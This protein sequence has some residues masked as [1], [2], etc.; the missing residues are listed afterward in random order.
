MR[1]RQ[2]TTRNNSEKKA[3]VG[4]TFYD[5]IGRPAVQVLPVPDN[6]GLVNFRA[7]FNNKGVGTPYTAEYIDKNKTG[8][9]SGADA[10]ESISGIGAA[11]Y[12]SEKN[13][14]TDGVGDGKVLNRDFIPKAEGYPFTQTL[15]TPDNTGRVAAQS[16]VGEAYRL[17]DN[18][19]FTE[20]F[21]GS[22]MQEELDRLF[23][24]EA[25]N[26]LRYQ[27][28]IVKDPNGQY[29][30]S[31]LD[32][33]G[34][35]IAT[36]LVGLGLDNLEDLPVAAGADQKQIDSELLGLKGVTQSGNGLNATGD[37][38]KYSKNIVLAQNTTIDLSYTAGLPSYETKC[39]VVD[40]SIGAN[41]K[42][43]SSDPRVVNQKCYDCVLEYELSLRNSQCPSTELLA[44]A[45]NRIG[46]L[47]D[48][49]FECTKNMLLTPANA[50]S[51]SIGAG[52]YTLSKTLRVNEEKL[53]LHQADYLASLCVGTLEQFQS[54]ELAKADLTSC[55]AGTCDDC[56][57]KVGS[58]TNYDGMDNTTGDVSA[59]ELKLSQNQYEEILTVC[60][61]L[62]KDEFVCDALSL[63][64]ESDFT[65]GGQYG[66]VLKKTAASSTTSSFDPNTGQ[67]TVSTSGGFFAKTSADG[68]FPSA[69]E[70]TGEMNPA[71]HIL[72]IYNENNRLP[73]RQRNI[74]S[75]NGAAALLAMKPSWRNPLY[76]DADKNGYKRHFYENDGKTVVYLS[77][78]KLPKD[79]VEYYPALQSGY[80]PIEKNGEFFAEPQ[81]LADV[82]DFMRI[83]KRSWMKSLL[84]YH[85][86][87][88]YLQY[89]WTNDK[90]ETV[91]LNNKQDLISSNRFDQLW[92]ETETY[93]QA[94]DAGFIVDGQL[95][96]PITG[97]GMKLKDPFWSYAGNSFLKIYGKYLLNNKYKNA[98]DEDF[99]T[100]GSMD[101]WTMANQ[102]AN[103]PGKE[104][105]PCLNESC[106]QKM[107][108]NDAEWAAFRSLYYA[109]KKDIMRDDATR[110]SIN[111]YSFNGCIGAKS[112]DNSWVIDNNYFMH[113]EQ[114][115]EQFW[116]CQTSEYWKIGGVNG[117]MNNGFAIFPETAL[118]HNPG[119]TQITIPESCTSTN[120]HFWGLKPQRCISYNC[121]LAS[122]PLSKYSIM[123]NSQ[124]CTYNSHSLYRDKKK[125]SVYNTT[126]TSVAGL[127]S[128]DKNC[129]EPVLG[130]DG[131]TAY[132]PSTCPEDVKELYDEMSAQATQS[133]Y[134]ECGQCPIARSLQNFISSLTQTNKFIS[135]VSNKVQ[136][137]CGAGSSKDVNFSPDLKAIVDDNSN[138][139]EDIF[140]YASPESVLTS[141]GFKSISTYITRAGV[142]R[143]RL[144]FKMK[145]NS[146][147]PQTLSFN[148]LVEVCCLVTEDQPKWI[149]GQSG[150]YYF[151][152]KGTYFVD[153]PD[154]Y[155]KDRKEVD[156]E[157]WT[158]CFDLK[159]C[160]PIPPK[161][162]TSKEIGKLTD[163]L[164]A[165]TTRIPN[166]PQNVYASYTNNPSDYAKVPLLISGDAA[167]LPLDLYGDNENKVTYFSVVSNLF[168]SDTDPTALEPDP[169]T[170]GN[171]V[172]AVKWKGQES[173]ITG[174]ESFKSKF[175]G[176]IT[177]DASPGINSTSTTPVQKTVDVF[178][179]SK[180]S[181]F[182]FENIMSFTR[183]KT[184]KEIGATDCT[185]NCSNYTFE[186]D[187]I[188]PNPVVGEPTKKVRLYGTTN[189]KTGICKPVI[190]F[191]KI[192]LGNN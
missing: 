88:G 95:P 60:D 101:I 100:R 80:T 103:C 19:H 6:S 78:I 40:Y 27:K 15:Y 75:D 71:E 145:V 76:F 150:G 127:G 144:E 37:E 169:T 26:S 134:A 42:V 125:V 119:A 74:I 188:V 90:N 102:I 171:L 91:V 114:S 21:Y 36:S 20:Y 130:A 108:R 56:R 161:C 64:M 177:V 156:I 59:T 49:T 16:G 34:K 10:F 128:M 122:I 28:N 84:P 83:R 157:V 160:L 163:L 110:Y 180:E 121:G 51:V 173:S 98:I 120:W 11:S 50:M 25:G 175:E 61:A 182:K 30:V 167:S 82:R 70:S 152:V 159:K 155:K 168:N 135:L 68:I 166:D 189:L 140:W 186:V 138:P 179:Y 14:F 132:V 92:T 124:S 129:W 77:V 5:Y 58:Y 87:Y 33:V 72:S 136:L 1:T 99:K 4:E 190:A 45:T 7:N 32:P 35:V 94:I 54:E 93:Q 48:Q 55:D 187:V 191:E 23:G 176:H 57:N 104:G 107:I 12:Y 43:T 24:L 79:P 86:E 153:I 113:K 89:C 2:Q 85:P 174:F 109:L 142:E 52:S 96:N 97:E 118:A 63:Q 13:P 17:A 185:S 111:N 158:S 178:L 131:N 39:E 151:T 154:S 183:I 38:Y 123:S 41:G 8:C 69:L 192:D 165:L 44:N 143:C 105:N 137:S 149:T 162:V 67:V 164:N 81:Y 115:P 47:G 62:C 141:D 46:V 9:A 106:P 184:V 66:E 148:D 73:I 3:V 172:S 31:Y 116:V 18:K 29:S 126:E 147:D 133:L 112:G 22:P 53:K 139:S 146:T 65:Q 181:N 170:A 117:G